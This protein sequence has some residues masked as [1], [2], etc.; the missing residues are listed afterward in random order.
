MEAINTA[1]SVL[2]PECSM[3]MFADVLCKGD[4][5]AKLRCSTYMCSQN[6]VEYFLALPTVE[7]EKAGG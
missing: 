3:L 4:T 7:L 1:V 2:C 6:G 5:K